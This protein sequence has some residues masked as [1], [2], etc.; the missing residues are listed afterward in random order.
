M[1]PVRNLFP[2]RLHR[3]ILRQRQFH[4]HVRQARHVEFRSSDA[5]SQEAP[6]EL[7]DARLLTAK[8]VIN[9]RGDDAR[10]PTS[11]RVR[12]KWRP[13][14]S[15]QLMKGPIKDNWGSTQSIRRIP[16]LPDVPTPKRTLP[17]GRLKIHLLPKVARQQNSVPNTNALELPLF[18]GARGITC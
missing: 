14:T 2:G 12:R 11:T 13:E 17:K 8:D 9:M 7:K 6:N 1:Q 5:P 18:Q 15:D 16:R 10:R 3:E 4:T